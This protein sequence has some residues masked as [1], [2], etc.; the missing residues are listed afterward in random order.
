MT[1]REIAE[2]KQL[3]NH[4]INLKLFFRK[5]Y[6]NL[7]EKIFPMNIFP[8][9]SSTLQLKNYVKKMKKKKR[10]NLINIR[11]SMQTLFNTATVKCLLKSIKPNTKTSKF[12][13]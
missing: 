12:N 11:K 7:L 5:I 1:W 6:Q 9:L 4:K 2:S 13:L 3:G 10:I 8:S